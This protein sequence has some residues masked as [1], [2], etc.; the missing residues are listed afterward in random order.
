MTLPCC[1]GSCTGVLSGPPAR[2]VPRLVGRPVIF[3][4]FFILLFFCS[5]Q[6]KEM[7]A[8]PRTSAPPPCARLFTISCRVSAL[9]RGIQNDAGRKRS[10]FIPRARSFTIACSVSAVTREIQSALPNSRAVS[11]V[12]QEVVG[13]GADL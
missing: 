1:F 12:V 8:A 4:S 13:M 6:L 5:R 10:F 3:F 2:E 7:A 11:A 9:T